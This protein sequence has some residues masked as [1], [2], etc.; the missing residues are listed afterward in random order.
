MANMPGLRLP[1]QAGNGIIMFF[2]Y[3]LKS[4]KEN[5]FYVGMTCKLEQRLKEHN[6]GSVKSTKFRKPYKLVYNKVFLTR[7]QARDFEKYLKIS[8]NKEKLIKSFAGVAEW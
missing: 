4:T 1:A 6:K 2:V 5:W 8:S 7:I 3:V